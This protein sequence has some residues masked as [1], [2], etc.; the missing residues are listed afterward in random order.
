MRSPS[1]LALAFSL[2]LTACIGVVDNSK[3]KGE[4]SKPAAPSAAAKI[5]PRAGSPLTGRATFVEHN[6][7]VE[8]VITLK[9]AP[10]GWHAVHVHETGDCSADDFTSS[11]G[12]FNP[13]GH[14]HGAPDAMQHHA[15]DLGNLWV[16]EDGDGYHS[17]FMP[18]LTVR[19]GTHSV[20]GRAIIVHEAADDLVT[21]PTGGAGARIG[22]G[23]IH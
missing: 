3:N 11:G 18:E 4:S 5:Q 15:G 12:H 17:V 9:N 13:D 10:P 1:T 14:V 22:C 23:E 7:G 6:G 21:Q 19:D 20:R 8:V 2:S 16:N